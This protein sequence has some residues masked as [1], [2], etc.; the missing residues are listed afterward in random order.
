MR[1]KV[2]ERY[3]VGIDSFEKGNIIEIVKTEDLNNGLQHVSY[4]IIKG[5]KPYFKVSYMFDN[6]SEFAARLT[7][8]ENKEH[9]VIYRKANET[10]ALDKTTGKK[11]VAKCSPE[12]TYDFYTGAKLAFDRLTGTEKKEPE[13][14]NV[15]FNG[16]VECV[17]TVCGWLTKGKIYEIKDGIFILDNG[18]KTVGPP[19][20]SFKEITKRF[21]STLKEVKKVKRYANVGEYV[22]VVAAENVPVTDGK[23]DYKN[24]DIIKIIGIENGCGQVRYAEGA[25]VN[26]MHKLLNAKE[27]VVIEGYEPPKP[28]YYN[29]KVVCVEIGVEENKGLYTVGKVYQFEN[30][31][32]K[33]DNGA[34]Y[35]AR[36]QIYNFDDWKN[37]TSSKFI[38]VV[39]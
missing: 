33:A 12:D 36:K 17:D 7:P 4:K 19:Y 24:G 32:L 5:K 38:E 1:F 37:W 26:G 28:K 35:P 23:P 30:G 34:T 25:D 39:E 31:F 18:K 27:Y 14:K 20:S 16:F 11:A 6:R 13:P 22:E 10:I 9:I 21:D 2:G 8:V 15:Y 29:G 3:K